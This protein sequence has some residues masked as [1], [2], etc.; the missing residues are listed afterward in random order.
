MASSPFEASV[1]IHPAFV[2]CRLKG[3]IRNMHASVGTTKR[4]ADPVGNKR[5][6]AGTNLRTL[7]LIYLED[8]S[9]Q[10]HEGT[11]ERCTDLVVFGDKNVHANVSGVFSSTR[12]S[13]SLDPTWDGARTFAA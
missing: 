13:Q 11:V 10:F 4:S 3:E 7:W 5:G 12:S 6:R 9:H 2:S 1:V 8:S